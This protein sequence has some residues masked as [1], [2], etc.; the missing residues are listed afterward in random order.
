[1]SRVFVCNECAPELSLDV[2]TSLGY[3]IRETGRCHHVD[4]LIKA[5]VESL[6]EIAENGNKLLQMAQTRVDRANLQIREVVQAGVSLSMAAAGKYEERHKFKWDVPEIDAL[7]NLRSVL[8]K[9][10]TEL[11]KGQLTHDESGI[12]LAHHSACECTVSRTDET[13]VPSIPS[14]PICIQCNYVVCRC[15]K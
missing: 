4:E 15:R 8:K 2:P 12:S 3:Y 7:R 11:D 1:M 14:G 9:V 13:P 10:A 5:E 6:R